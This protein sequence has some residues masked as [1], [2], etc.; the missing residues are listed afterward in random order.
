VT[1]SLRDSGVR[2][3]VL[4]I[5]GTTTPISFVTGVL[6]PYA[7]SHLREFFASQFGIAELQEVLRALQAEWAYDAALGGE[8]PALEDSPP[9]AR[10]ESMADY[11]DWLMDR[12]RKSSGLKRLQ[13]MIWK[14]GYENGTLRGEVYPDV[15]HALE[16]WHD[17]Q[18]D[19]AIYSSGSELAQ[20]LLFGST[21]AGDLTPLIRFFFDTATGPKTASASYERIAETMER[22]CGE[23]LFVSDVVAE[24][25]AASETG[26]PSLLCFRPGNAVQPANDYAVIESFDEI[27]A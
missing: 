21:P 6:F 26:V 1:I 22:V 15:V 14:G 19:V 4:D 18:V 2:S 25:D 3:V 20:R 16:R 9:R 10:L 8:P 23:L 17:T 12:D 24:L 27:V 5:E 11:V 7:R 13:G